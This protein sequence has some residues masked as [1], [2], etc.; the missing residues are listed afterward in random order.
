MKDNKGLNLRKA[1][2]SDCYFIW[3]LRNEESTRKESFQS[4]IIPCEKHQLWFNSKLEDSNTRIY[5]LEKG[6]KQIGQIRFEISYS[7]IAEVHFAIDPSSRGKGF[8][9]KLLVL[10]CEKLSNDLSIMEIVAH[11]KENNHRSIDTFK[12]AGFK[13][14]GVCSY[15]GHGCIKMVYI[16][17]SVK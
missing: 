3:K 15:K 8:G 14:M 9:K 11:V 17:R 6:G 7:K 5:V 12:R 2:D 13:E 4:E 1:K 10:G 16:S